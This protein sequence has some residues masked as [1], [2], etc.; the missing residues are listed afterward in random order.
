MPDPSPRKRSGLR[1]FGLVGLRA[2]VGRGGGV[3]PFGLVELRALARW[4]GVIGWCTVLRH[5]GCPRGA[6]RD[7]WLLSIVLVAVSRCRR[8]HRSF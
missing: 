2:L 8:V 4:A 3:G 1:P 6:G 5:P 7:L